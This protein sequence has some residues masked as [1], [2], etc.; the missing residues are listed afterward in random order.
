M[1]GPGGGAGLARGPGVR[2]QLRARSS[3]PPRARLDRGGKAPAKQHPGNLALQ[4]DGA[5]LLCDFWL[6]C[7]PGWEQSEG[8]PPFPAAWAGVRGFR[9]PEFADG[10][11]G[12]AH[13]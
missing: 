10:L 2:V 7:M 12:R 13:P 9:V 5:E 3:G 11:G 8:C 4:I 6:L 1:S